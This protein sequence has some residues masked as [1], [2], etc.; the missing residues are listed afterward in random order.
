MQINSSKLFQGKGHFYAFERKG[1]GYELSGSPVV[2]RLVCVLCVNYFQLAVL[3]HNTEYR[4]YLLSLKFVCVRVCV[5]VCVCVV[6]VLCC[7]V[8]LCC[9]V[10][11]VV[12]CVL[13]VVCVC[14]V[15]CVVCIPTSN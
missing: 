9:V 5:C 11:C 13:C 4:L 12:C 8:V 10:L 7:C 3:H 6:Y 14:V 1:Q 15:C 2:A